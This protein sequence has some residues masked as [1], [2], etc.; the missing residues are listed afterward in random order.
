MS[1]VSVIVSLS[2]A[3]D[4]LTEAQHAKALEYL[5]LQ[6][7]IRDRRKIIQVLCQHNPDHLT[8][9]IRDGVSAYD[10]MIRQVHQAVDL[11]ATLGDLEVFMNDMIKLS[12]TSKDAKTPSVEDFVQ[13]LHT[14]MGASHRFLHQ[15]AKNGKEVSQWFNEYV[16]AAAA[17]FK[18]QESSA[19]SPLI[20][21]SLV[22]AFEELPADDQ[23]TVQ[24]EVDIYAKYL[25]ALHESS[26][27]RVR[28]VIDNKSKTEY[29][30]G[31][32][33]ARWQDLMDSTLITPDKM[34]GP[35]RQGRSKSVKQDAMKDV[36]GEVKAS[37]VD[38]AKADK[39]VGE[40]TPDAP[41]AENTIR[42]L[43]PKFRELLLARQ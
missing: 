2:T 21:D 10:P 15:V 17:N 8:Q 13:L 9:A 26:A 1:I 34:E 29:G 22:S 33:L 42:L 11:S 14:H 18:Q 37:G 19:S 40:K 32:Y 6:L 30:P 31:S 4:E 41:S 25:Q 5:S 16:H 36:D 38:S 39:I 7:A 24:K 28:D 3:S 27:A 23:S 43:G 35:V 12:K 20:T